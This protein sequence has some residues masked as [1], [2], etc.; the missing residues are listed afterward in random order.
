M[1][2]PP[3]VYER[4][5][6]LVSRGAP[7]SV[8][9]LNGQWQVGAP[10]RAG[11][12]TLAKQS[13]LTR[14]LEPVREGERDRLLTMRSLVKRNRL[15]LATSSR[16]TPF[17]GGFLPPAAQVPPLTR[18]PQWGSHGLLAQALALA[19]RCPTTQKRT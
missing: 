9:F 12:G 2:P 14:V 13:T 10:P 18:R 11:R 8:D 15:Q 7:D 19:L 4:Y 5:A 6:K 17:G 1:S 3:L 16:E